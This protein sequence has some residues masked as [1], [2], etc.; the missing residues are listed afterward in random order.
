MAKMI[1]RA[2]IFLRSSEEWY[3]TK[4]LVKIFKR[5]HSEDAGWISSENILKILRRKDSMKILI[6]TFSSKNLQKIFILYLF[7]DLLNK[8]L[9][10]FVLILKKNKKKWSNGQKWSEDLLK[11]S[12]RTLNEI[13]LTSRRP[14]ASYLWRG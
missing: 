11:T 5:A 10:A 3:L 12:K 9:L 6:K 13:F 7:W 2:Q 4:I 1:P 14:R 8:Y